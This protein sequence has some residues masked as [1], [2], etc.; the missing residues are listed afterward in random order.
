MTQPNDPVRGELLRIYASDPEKIRAFT[1]T[2]KNWRLHP[3]NGIGTEFLG[4]G[5]KWRIIHVA[6]PYR[7][8]GE[9]QNLIDIVAIEI[10]KKNRGK[11]RAAHVHS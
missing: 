9:K 10:P 8:M 1:T 7:P 5:K 6:R 4:L 3:D 11:G 2:E